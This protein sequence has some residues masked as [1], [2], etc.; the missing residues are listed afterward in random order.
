MT[1]YRRGRAGRRVRP[2]ASLLLLGWCGLT[3]AAVAML[4]PQVYVMLALPVFVGIGVILWLLPDVGGV[5]EPAMATLFVSFIVANCLWPN[6]IALDLPGLPWINPPRIVTF[7][8][9]ALAV[10]GYASSSRM[11]RGRRGARCDPAAE[12]CPSGYSRQRR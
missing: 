11:R 4:P 1:P 9:L 2:F 12:S 8:L 10:Y 6:Y 3:G 5:A 7:A